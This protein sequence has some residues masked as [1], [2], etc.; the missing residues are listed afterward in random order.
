[1]IRKN[2]ARLSERSMLAEERSSAIRKSGAW[3]SNKIML[4]ENGAT[5]GSN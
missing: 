5:I 1:M 2:E 4:R 3:F